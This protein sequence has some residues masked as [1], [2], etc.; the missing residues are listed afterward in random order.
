MTTNDQPQSP[1]SSYSVNL[2]GIL[3]LKLVNSVFAIVFLTAGLVYE[4]IFPDQKQVSEIILAVAALA[5]ALPVFANAFQGLF[6]RG[7]KYITDQLVSLAILASMIEGNFIVAAVL[8]IVLAFGHLL[9]EKSIM[10][11]EEA[12]ASLKKLHSRKARRIEAGAEVLVEPES[13]NVDDNIVCYPGEVIAADGA[14][15]DGESMVNQAPITG[16]SVPVE[17]YAGMNVFAGTINVSG[18]IT[19]RVTRLSRDTLFNKVVTLLKE[20]ERSKAPIVKIIEKYLDMYFPFVIMVAALTMFVTNDVTRA[21]AVLVISCPCALVLAS[22]TAMIASLVVATRNGIM[23]KNTAFLETLSDIDTLVFD[24]TGTV[25]YGRLEVERMFPAPD[26]SED[27]LLEY[28]ALCA[29]GSIHP[30]SASIVGFAHLKGVRFPPPSA[31]KEFHGRGVT[32][33]D[34]SSRYYLGKKDWVEAESGVTAIENPSDS[35]NT[36]V[37][38]AG[39]GKFLGEIIF[40][41]KPRPEI[42]SAVKACRENGVKSVWLLT[43]D[44]AEVGEQIGRYLGVDGCISQCLPQDKLDF[45]NKRKDEGAKVMFVG[46]GINDALALKASDVGVAIARTGS[47]IAIQNSDIILNTETLLQL[48]LMFTLSERT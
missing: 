16:E 9:E 5:I 32:A 22:P 7:G 40:S 21:I 17:A 3:Q 33:M 20:A 27:Q 47:D 11:I 44:R 29:S 2:S 41:D 31:R 39:N 26:V 43:G 37:W 8:P 30:V 28:A 15:V 12:I 42:V 19:I 6:D 18:K 10:G 34:G 36:S 46:D 23:V 25:T 14:V 4:T 24:K 13:L 1:D 45:V 35:G 38:V 48:P